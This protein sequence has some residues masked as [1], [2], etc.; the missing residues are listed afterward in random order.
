MPDFA[1][2]LSELMAEK[3][4]KSHELAAVLGVNTSSVNDWKR[5]KFQVFLSNALKIADFFGCSLEFLMGRSET[6]IDYTPQPCPPFYPR[7]LAVVEER[8]FT[9]YLMRKESPIKGAYFNK[10][11]QGADPLVPT[12][13]F[14][15]D[16]LGV[17]L[18][19]LVGRDCNR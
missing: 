9:T 14:A 1:E 16:Y 18:D 10:W 13:A 8:G 12:L 7:F 2:R 11:K 15:A 6:V 3:E 5:G 4:T 19:Y 17:T